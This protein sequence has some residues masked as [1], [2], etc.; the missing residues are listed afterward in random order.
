M[1]PDPAGLLAQ[2]QAIAK[3]ESL[4]LC[5]EHPLIIIDP[6]GLDCVY[7]NDA[8]NGVESIDHD[9]NSGECG[10][11]GGTWAP[12]YVDENWSTFNQKTKCSRWAPLMVREAMR[13]SITRIS[14]PGLKRMTMATV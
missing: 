7:A 9:S 1:S 6:T 8:G 2:N 3:L 13:R 5:D 14:Q 12:G 4:R 11:N 10:S